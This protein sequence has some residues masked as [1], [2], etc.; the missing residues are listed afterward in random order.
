[1]E[2]WVFVCDKWLDT[3]EE[4]GK[5]IRELYAETDLKSHSRKLYNSLCMCYFIKVQN[6]VEGLYLQF[7]QVVCSEQLTCWL[8]SLNVY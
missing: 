6:T 5:T 3:G 7:L 1:V 4:D 8:S 2:E